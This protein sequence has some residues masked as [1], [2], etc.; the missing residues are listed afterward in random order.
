L[1]VESLQVHSSGAGLGTGSPSM[2]AAALDLVSCCPSA[3]SGG[4]QTKSSEAKMQPNENRD[5]KSKL[6]CLLSFCV[7]DH[8]LGTK[9]GRL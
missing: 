9:S 5:G 7:A 8:P 3:G 1:C 6:Q 4:R 2:A